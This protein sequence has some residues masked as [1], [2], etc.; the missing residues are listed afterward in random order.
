MAFIALL[1][2]RRML[3]RELETRHIM[4]KIQEAPKTGCIMAIPT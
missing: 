4:I 2:D 3:T 1:G